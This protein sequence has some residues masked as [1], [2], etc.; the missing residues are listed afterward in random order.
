[1]DI[2]RKKKNVCRK[3][4]IHWLQNVHCIKAE[5]NNINKNEKNNNYN[6]YHYYYD[7]DDYYHYYYYYH[8]Y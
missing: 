7:D 4:T 1:M 8:Y 5:R 2:N 6:N 3:P